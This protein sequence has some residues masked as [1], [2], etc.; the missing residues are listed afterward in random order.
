MQQLLTGDEMMQHIKQ[1]DFRLAFVGMS[2]CGK[3]YKS[4]ILQDN[5][6]FFW[7]EVDRAIQK[8]LGFDSMDQIASWM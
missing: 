6:G 1:G 7:Y 3:S 8:S 5:A 4:R 2:N